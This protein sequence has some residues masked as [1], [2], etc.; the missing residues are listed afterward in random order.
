MEKVTLRERL[1]KLYHERDF[2]GALEAA[3]PALNGGLADIVHITGLSLVA[4]GWVDEGYD[5]CVA[6]LLLTQPGKEWPRNCAVQFIDAQ[7]PDRALEFITKSLNADPDDAYSNYVC[8]LI[9]GR[10]LDWDTALQQFDRA[11]ALDPWDHRY[12]VTRAFALHMLQRYEDALF[13]YGQVLQEY[14]LTPKDREDVT[15]G[16]GAVWCNMGEPRKSLEVLEQNYAEST[17]PLTI[18]NRSRCYLGFGDYARGWEMYRQRHNIVLDNTR[19]LAVE[20]TDKLAQSLDDVRG[21]TVAFYGEQ[22]YGDI[23][24]FLRYALLLRPLVEE[25]HIV[26]RP[27]VVRMAYLLDAMGWFTVIP[28]EQGKPYDHCDVTVGMMDAP[29]LFGTTVETIPSGPYFRPVPHGVVREHALPH[30]LRRVGICWAGAKRPNDIRAAA[31][32]QSRS[33]PFEDIVPLLMRYAGQID[34]YSL[35]I[36]QPVPDEY[37]DYIREPLAKDFD[38]LDTAAVLDQLD[39][40]ITVDTAIAHLASALQK[41]TW[42]M[43][44][45]G[46]CWR[47]F[48]DGRRDSPWYPTARLYRKPKLGEWATVIEEVGADLEVMRAE[49]V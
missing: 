22:G 1:W 30:G 42:V 18:Y 5:F 17:Y 4:Q 33:V 6:S 16:L 27:S 28:E 12:K 10:L 37:K 41:P 26:V 46:H 35:Q 2:T 44:F 25:L 31:W 11:I 34:F 32:D 47:W 19:V 40:V 15:N 29:A 14:T 13:G 49:C 3:Q 23:F 7:Q 43:L 48:Y 8:G 39:L 36:D 9:H 38:W 24:M 20:T 45:A 21:K